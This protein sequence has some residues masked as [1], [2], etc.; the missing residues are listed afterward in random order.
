M[1]P[2]PAPI[3]VP[4]PIQPG[5]PEATD[6]EPA[7]A[8]VV[9]V[10]DLETSAA[11]GDASAITANALAPEDGPN[12]RLKSRS[13]TPLPA[14]TGTAPLANQVAGHDGVMTDES[15][16]LVIKVGIVVVVSVHET[17]L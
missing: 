3:P 2:A 4:S 15:G 7:T 8:P 5:T 13:G 11:R 6:L 16:S 10:P 14:I 12:K 1:P 17:S 9:V